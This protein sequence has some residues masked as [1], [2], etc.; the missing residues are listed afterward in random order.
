MRF[1][2]TNH[3]DEDN[4][5]YQV[6]VLGTDGI[7]EVVGYVHSITRT[8]SDIA[9]SVFIRNIKGVK[10]WWGFDNSGKR[11]CSFATSRR[12]AATYVLAA[13]RN[14]QEA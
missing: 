7:Y 3:Y 12:Q 9:G 5:R 6:A 8:H 11:V 4:R 13:H 1:I 14:G 10:E 2:K